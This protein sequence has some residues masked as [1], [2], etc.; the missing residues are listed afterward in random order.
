MMIDK[1]RF[2]EKITIYK[3]YIGK[4]W[5]FWGGEYLS[6]DDKRFV[7]GC[8]DYLVWVEQ[9]NRNIKEII[10]GEMIEGIIAFKDNMSLLTR[11]LWECDSV[12]GYLCVDTDDPYENENLESKLM[13]KKLWEIIGLNAKDSIEG[14]GWIDSY[15]RKKFSEKEMD[16]FSENVVIK[17]KPYI[18]ET[19]KVLEIGCA[20]GLTMF[21]LCNRVQDYYAI[22]L[23]T[24][25]INKNKEKANVMGI[26]NLHLYD[27][28][29]H[30]ITSIKENDFDFII[31]NSVTQC[32]CGINY[33]RNIIRTCIDLIKDRGYIF[34]GDVMDR[35][36]KNV[37]YESLRLYK[38]QHPTSRTKLDLSQELYL[39]KDYFRDLLVDF[40]EIS[41]IEFSDKIHTIQNE[42]TR[43]RYD[44]LIY[45]EK[46]GITKK[47]TT[48][49]KKYQFAISIME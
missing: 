36:K 41:K 27:I 18:N 12:K 29:A 49:K 39:A 33:L 44:A 34:I 7:E 46:T 45:I 47:E 9:N 17:L 15:E 26:C 1:D 11:I 20:S 4:R 3:S 10:D 21:K 30:E 8:F 31:M 43:Y 16:E 13:R 6:N 22:D 23:S 24:I 38:E 32:F 5:L 28:P 14:G 48:L 35:N 42:L 2:Q 40:N 19:S 25:N 37:F